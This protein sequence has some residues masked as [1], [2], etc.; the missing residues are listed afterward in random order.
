VSNPFPSLFSLGFAAI[1]IIAAIVLYA[2]GSWKGPD[3]E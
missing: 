2:F 1:A 3:I